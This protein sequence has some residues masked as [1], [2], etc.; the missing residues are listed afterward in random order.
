MFV[1]CLCRLSSK[2]PVNAA[3]R[4]KKTK[5]KKNQKKKKKKQQQ[6]RNKKTTKNNNNNNKRNPYIEDNAL[7]LSGNL[8]YVVRMEH[9]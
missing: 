8:Q 5:T 9:F 1:F 7:Y 4:K 2:L 3:A 6:Q